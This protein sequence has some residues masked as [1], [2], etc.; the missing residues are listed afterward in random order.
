LPRRALL[1]L[2]SVTGHGPDVIRNIAPSRLVLVD[3]A[4]V[5]AIFF[6]I[7]GHT[8]DVLLAPAYREGTV[9]AVWLF[10]RGL[11]A[12]MFFIL[13]GVSFM[14]STTHREEKFARPDWG[15]ARRSGRFVFFMTLGYAMHLPAGSLEQLQYVDAATW[16]AWFQVDVL[17]C[18]GLTLLTLQ[19]LV[20]IAR[21]PAKLAQTSAAVSAA[22]ILLTPLVWNVDWAKRFPIPLAAYFTSQQ[23]SNFPIFPWAGYVFFGAFLGYQL[24]RWSDSSERSV[25]M[26]AVSGAALGLTGLLLIEPLKVV[27]A[28]LDFWRTGPSLF[29]IRSGC[30]CLLLSLIAYVSEKYR[31][32]RRA[33]RTLAQ[34]SLLIYF[35][36]VCL[37]YGSIWNLGL[38]QLV[39]ASLA[40]LPT[41]AAIASLLLCMMLLAWFWNWLKHA[42]P[43]RSYL[44]RFAV[45]LLAIFHPWST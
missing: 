42:D 17:Q 10:L 14:V 1:S 31:V 7:Q 36:H 11:T 43:W 2:R 6:M 45:I 33:C 18:I 8:L 9:F 40:P 26:L 13:S 3:L 32:P 20:L 29:L 38:R 39:G 23:G 22:V 15:M 16:Q 34:E 21:S 27:Y 19:L 41:L 12:P 44:L 37:L 25:R 5:L 4:R 24:R 28:N 30:V 35:V